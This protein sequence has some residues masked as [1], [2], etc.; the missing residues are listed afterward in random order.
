MKPRSTEDNILACSAQLDQEQLID[1]LGDM[2][3]PHH[4]IHLLDT[5]RVII[6]RSGSI[7]IVLSSHMV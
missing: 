6:E 3:V 5:A 4:Q 1:G 7:L 2:E